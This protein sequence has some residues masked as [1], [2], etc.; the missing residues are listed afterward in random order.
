MNRRIGRLRLVVLWYV[1]GCVMVLSQ[2]QTQRQTSPLT[3]GLDREFLS[4]TATVNG[5]T[6]H[7]V[8]GGKGPTVIL[9]HGFPQDWFE[10]RPIMPTLAKQFT[11]VAVDL[12]GIGGSISAPDGY[13]AA[14][15]AEDIY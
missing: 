1:A 14:N 4:E 13:D 11:V 10:Y 7:Y 15:M 2:S 5:I 9:I 3:T 6:L 12:R 8:R